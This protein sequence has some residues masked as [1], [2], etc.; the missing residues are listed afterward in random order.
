MSED[1]QVTLDKT[2]QVLAAKTNE[3]TI[4]I[5]SSTFGWLIN[6]PFVTQNMVNPLKNDHISLKL[7]TVQ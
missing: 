5:F 4:P 2:F 1:L 3:E 7:H 6:F